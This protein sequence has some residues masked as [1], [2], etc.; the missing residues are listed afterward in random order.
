MSGSPKVAVSGISG[1]IG[2]QVAADLLSRGYAVH[3][4]VRSNVPEKVAHLTSLPPHPGTLKLFEADLN[5]PG[6]F[7]AA[8]LGCDYAIH[9]ASPYF[10][11]S[12]DPQR[13]LVDP[14][15]NG[16]LSFLRSC[17]NASVNKVVLTSSLAAI[18]DGGVKGKVFSESDWNT[19]SNL[20]QLAYYYSKTQAEK[21]AW[22]FVEQHAPDMKLVVIN[23]VGVLGPSLVTS[24]NESM[25][26]LTSTVNGGFYGIVDL[27]FSFVDVR[28]VSEAHIR[29]MESDTASGRYICASDRLFSHREMVD[30]AVEAGFNPPTKDLT[31]KL[32]CSAIKMMSHC[33]PGGETGVYTRNHIGNPVVPTNA[34]IVKD[35]RMQFRDPADTVRETYQYLIKNGHLNNASA[36]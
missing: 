2:A 35:L 27:D 13:D 33:I 32:F 20:H 3:G 36:K 26:L 18:A 34:K 10:L 11:N 1:F 29:A 16:T 17:K 5:I 12:K 6:S 25:G 28:D 24:L 7:D 9:V 31:G 19:R 8:V 4:T 23:P 14:A 21:A 15:V 30:L 22:N